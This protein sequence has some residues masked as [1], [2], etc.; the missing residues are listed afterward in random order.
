M[1]K[2]GFVFVSILALALGL[3][4]SVGIPKTAKQV[5]ERTPAQPESVQYRAGGHVLSFTPQK[6]Y[7]TSTDHALSVSFAGGK[8]VQP[9]GSAGNSQ[10]RAAGSPLSRVIYPEV[11]PGVDIVYTAAQDGIAESA[12]LL[13]IG[14]DADAIR[15]RYNVPVE[16]MGDG[17]LQFSFEN[18]YMTESAPAAWQE[19]DGR[20]VNVG[21]HFETL[22]ANG[23]GII[24][25]GYNAER[26][27]Y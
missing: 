18:G 17:S 6:V 13:S 24:L 22:G 2:P 21:V 26:R 4:T 11:W 7:M 23:I 14:A 15:L 27:A 20:R 3:S 16:L 9:Q 12:Y 25:E 8:R 10:T 5:D 1:K 19:I